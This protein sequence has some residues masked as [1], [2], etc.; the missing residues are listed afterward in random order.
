MA[1]PLDIQS[2]LSRHQQAIVATLRDAM[3]MESNVIPPQP[4]VVIGPFYGQMKY[5][6]G[7]VDSNFAPTSAH[8]GKLLRPT[9]LLL[10]Y[11]ASGA[12]NMAN[13]TLI[14]S[15]QVTTYLR[16]ALPAAATLELT[17]NCTL[18]HDDIE[19]GDTERRHR[20]TVWNEWGIP[21]ATNT[22]DGMYTLA[23]L[24]LW[25]VL[26]EGVE[27][28][29][30]AQ[31]GTLLDRTCLAIFEGQYL[32]MSFEQRLDISLP[33]Y[34]NMINRKTAALMA[35]ASE[36][37]GLLGTRN[38]G[39]ISSLRRFGWI[40]GRAF[41]VRDDLLGIWEAEE[42]GKLPA[43]DIYRRKKTLPVIH[44]LAH[45]NERDQA[46]LH[47]IY[48]QKP[49]VTPEQVADILAIF[50]RTH[51]RAYCQEFLSHQ[52]AEAYAALA[53][54]PRRNT[55]IAVRAFQDMETIVAFLEEAAH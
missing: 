36:M 6:L 46:L 45:A 47:T 4:D 30:A 44:A 54:I 25:K 10:A 37:G 53:D 14:F 1:K 15:D 26:D 43:G 33:M 32:D 7:W 22:G 29:I 5:H 40:L 3:D 41:Q 12:W 51:T 39:T 48:T 8:P 23:R 50:T 2:T 24:T 27:E 49:P 55:P 19:D 11:E 34:L 13:E 42:L 16:R 31:L 21:Q 52:C 9:L 28:G 18:I 20:P 38:A 35:C 17:H